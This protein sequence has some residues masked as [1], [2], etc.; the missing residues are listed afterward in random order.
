MP[1]LSWIAAQI[2][3]WTG[4][5][6]SAAD[7]ACAEAS[8][9][10]PEVDAVLQVAVNRVSALNKP[11]IEVINMKRQFAHNCPKKRRHW[12]HIWAGI[13]AMTGHLNVPKWLSEDVHYF[14]T[15]RMAHK[16]RDCRRS[17]GRLRHVYWHRKSTSSCQAAKVRR[18]EREAAKREA[19]RARDEMLPVRL[20]MPRP[21]RPA[22]QSL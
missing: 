16:W 17:V 10:W 5:V 3:V 7:T 2:L 1:A 20:L 15:P 11:L 18:L 22:T 13:R 21:T 12:R 6:F 4:S 9:D 14:C 19:A 8:H